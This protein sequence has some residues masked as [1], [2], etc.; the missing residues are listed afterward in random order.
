[1][2]FQPWAGFQARGRKHGLLQAMMATTS[3]S[4]RLIKKGYYKGYYKD[5]GKFR[6][7]GVSRQ[8]HRKLLVL[9]VL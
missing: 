3:K 8:H 7:L 4:R 1:M 2:T 6:G 5:C 9:L